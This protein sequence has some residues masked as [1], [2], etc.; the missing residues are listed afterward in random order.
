MFFEWN[1]AGPRLTV[2]LC[3]VESLNFHV[4]VVR[5]RTES[6][7]GE[8]AKSSTVTARAAA[9]D[10]VAMASAAT[11]ATLAT[12]GMRVWIDMHLGRAHRDA[13]SRFALPPCAAT[14]SRRC[15]SAAPRD[16]RE[17]VCRAAR[18]RCL[19]RTGATQRAGTRAAP[20]PSR[21]ARMN[22]ER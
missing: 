17:W 5:A 9:S 8:K 12:S 19:V 10:E 4:T 22:A 7:A 13:H 20:V 18:A 15:S 2:T 3:L 1:R 16:N 21:L 11:A 14:P 6:D